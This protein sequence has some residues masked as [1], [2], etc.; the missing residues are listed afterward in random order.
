MLYNLQACQGRVIYGR[1][2]GGEKLFFEPSRGHLFRW[3]GDAHDGRSMDVCDP[4]SRCSDSF[5]GF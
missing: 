2:I 4:D 3:I 1:T 5:F